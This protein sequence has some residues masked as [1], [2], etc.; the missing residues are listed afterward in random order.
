MRQKS[1]S[2]V[3]VNSRKSSAFHLIGS[4]ASETPVSKLPEII[5][6]QLRQTI[7]ISVDHQYL[8]YLIMI[9]SILLKNV[10]LLIMPMMIHFQKFHFQ[11]ML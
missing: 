6:V 4:V 7:F 2:I 1:D 11:L 10:I 5:C 9:F 3:K 8:T